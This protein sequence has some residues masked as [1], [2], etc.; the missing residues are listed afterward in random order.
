MRSPSGLPLYNT[1]L[2]TTTSTTLTT[3]AAAVVVSVS[4]AGTVYLCNLEQPL[5]ISPRPVSSHSYLSHRPVPTAL[6]TLN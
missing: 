6:T 2:S 3:A 4:T 1:T 5:P